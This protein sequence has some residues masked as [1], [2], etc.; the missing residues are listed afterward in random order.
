MAKSPVYPVN[1]ADVLDGLA[2]EVISL[3][4]TDPDAGR[5]VGMMSKANA[6]IKVRRELL[7]YRAARKELK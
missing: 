1:A 6:Y 2:Q 5:A 7:Q 3:V 4:G